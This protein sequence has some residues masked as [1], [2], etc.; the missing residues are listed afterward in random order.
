[1]TLLLLGLPLSRLALW[2]SI[3]PQLNGKPKVP[4]FCVLRFAREA[5]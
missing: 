2:M 3:A 1:M 5:A 4:R